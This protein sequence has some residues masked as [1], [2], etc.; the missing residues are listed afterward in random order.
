MKTILSP[1][2]A[3]CTVGFFARLSYALARSPVLP[4]FALYLGAGP[5]A[6]GLA[7]GISTVTGIFF[8]LPSG[9]L[10][11]VIG[12]KSTMLIGLVFFA[13]MPFTYLFIHNY[14]LLVLIRFVHGLA[15]AIYGP[16]SMAVVMDVAGNK[17]GEMLSWF[18][19]VTII[20]NLLGAPVGG[21]ILYSMSSGGPSFAEFQTVYIVSGIAGMA[22]L[23]IAL[24]LLTRREN[25]ENGR[26]LKESYKRF[27]SGI[28]EVISDKRVVITSNM[29]GL[30][31][32]TVG[33]L[34]AFLPVYV[35]TV[36][37]LNEFQAGLLWGIQVLTTI[38]SKPIMGRISDRYGRKPLIAAGMILCAV[39][40]GWI[41]LLK[42]FYLLMFAAIAFGFGEAFV[43]SS[44]AALVAD[45]CKEK[46]FGTAMGT[47]G[48][49]FDVGHAS[50]PMLAGFLIAKI[51][52]LPA[53]L[54]MGGILIAVLPVFVFAVK[55]EKSS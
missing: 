51:D 39:S 48:T 41:P 22:S 15:T 8:K 47:F 11:D 55:E 9:A 19:S 32:M 2:T 17:K 12:R 16:V 34:E 42:D 31:N 49:I 25:A 46:H 28:K 26:S 53:F 4:L 14:N 20:G 27:H 52:Y 35:V 44:S 7:V 36:A 33:A 13:V 29:E 38:M 5:E 54:I 3:L 40:F 43:T 18:S 45:I 10:S 37:G 1:F 24:K 30:Q 21:F 23:M 50:G 6:I